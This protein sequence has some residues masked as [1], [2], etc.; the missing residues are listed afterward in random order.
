MHAKQILL[1]MKQ[2]REIANKDIAQYNLQVQAAHAAA[3]G[4]AQERLSILDKWYKNYLWNVLQPVFV[5]EQS[6]KDSSFIEQIKNKYKPYQI[7]SANQPY[8]F[9]AEKIWKTL[10]SSGEYGTNQHSLFLAE[11]KDL[12]LELGILQM[13][14]P[15]FDGGFF[16]KDIEE[17]EVYLKRSIKKVVEDDFSMLYL[18][19]QLPVVALETHL[20]TFN[21]NDSVEKYDKFYLLLTDIH[22]PS[23]LENFKKL[24][25]LNTKHIYESKLDTKEVENVSL[26]APV[27]EKIEKRK[28]QKH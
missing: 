9:L 20:A 16:V 22:Y 15:Q 28:N 17:L 19:H 8:R 1:E 26:E 4:Q 6:S 18:R 13:E 7:F 11:L 5:D 10:T 14:F 2:Q 24:F 25:S 12:S 27:V 3:I 21:L 23:E